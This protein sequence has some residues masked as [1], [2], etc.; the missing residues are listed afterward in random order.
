MTKRLNYLFRKTFNIIVLI[1]VFGISSFDSSLC[2]E[3]VLM[4][5]AVPVWAEGR[6]KEMNLTLGFRG[7]FQKNNP[8]NYKLHITASTL[9]RVSLNGTFIGYGPARTA[10]GYFRVDEYDLGNQVR[11]GENI[12]AIEVA[13]YNV[14]SYYILDQPSFLQ[15]EIRSDGKVVLAT[16]TDGS[17]NAFQPDQRLQ[18]VERYSFQRPFTE[19]Y[20]LKK[21]YDQWK[22]SAKVT[23]ESLKLAIQPT[24]KLLPRNLLLPEYKKDHPKMVCSRGTIQFQKPEKYKKDR[25][26]TQI[27]EKLKGYKESELEVLPSQFMQEI[28]NKSQDTLAKPYVADKINLVG[29]EFAIFDFGTNLSG[30]IGGKIS[31]AVPSKVVFYF[32]EILTD[33]DVN[34]KKRMPDVN[35]QVVYELDPGDYS[36]ETFESYTFKYLKVIVLKGKCQLQD[37]YLREYAYPENPKASFYCSNNRLNEIYKA[38][39]Q[40]FRQNAV[41]IFMDCPSRERAG[42]LCDSYFSAIMEKDF[43]G[44]SAVAHNFYENYALPEKFAFLPEGNASNVLSGRSQRWGV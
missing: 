12:L 18:K 13:G 25:S 28:T 41:D 27:S 5:K 37:I 20:R 30:F 31:C 4:K 17:F 3:A 14:N 1:V 16:G 22:T 38:A 8:Q 26:L 21:D 36:L 40:S 7:I 34:T 11:N 33:G 15:A 39:R 2:S 42:W 6:E 19:Y 9:Y 44:H 29:N 10:H 23:V 43:T 24:V 35:N 32:D